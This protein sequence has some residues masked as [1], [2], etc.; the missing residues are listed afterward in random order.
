MTSVEQDNHQ[1]QHSVGTRRPSLLYTLR[2]LANR[3]ANA[4]ASHRKE[5]H[6]AVDFPSYEVGKLHNGFFVVTPPTRWRSRLWATIDLFNFYLIPAARLEN[7]TN[8]VVTQGAYWRRCLEGKIQPVEV[9]LDS[10]DSAGA[11]HHESSWGPAYAFVLC[12]ERGEI[13]MSGNAD[14]GEDV[15]FSRLTTDRCP[16]PRKVPC[17]FVNC[18][19]LR[20][21]PE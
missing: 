4:S 19:V 13:Y 10:A 15:V 14:L 20:K 2:C 11:L 7:Y 21:P 1:F 12:E 9:L 18:T 3:C 17:S 5:T 6:K 8:V 16:D